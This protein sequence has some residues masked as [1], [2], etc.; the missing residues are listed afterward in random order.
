MKCSSA[1]RRGRP[2]RKRDRM[3]F[4]SDEFY[5][6]SPQEMGDLF[7]ELPGGL[8]P[9]GGDRRTMQPGIEIR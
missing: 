4:S 9:Y 8:D 3:K 5:F 7:K 1:F 6:K 2:F